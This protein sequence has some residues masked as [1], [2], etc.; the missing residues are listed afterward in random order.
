MNG[1]FD[2]QLT[3]R[4]TVTSPEAATP[5]RK[6]RCRLLDR[7]L[8]RCSSEEIDDGVGLCAHHLAQA[9]RD[10]LRLTGR[11]GSRRGRR[12]GTRPRC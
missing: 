5:A 7:M 12:R 8:N 1:G 4:A 10:F 2:M 11:A 3:S 9:H 6:P